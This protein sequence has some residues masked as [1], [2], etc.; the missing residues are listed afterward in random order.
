[1]HLSVAYN[2]DPRLIEEVVKNKYP[3]Y[4]FYASAQHTMVG[5]GRPSFIL[6]GPDREAIQAQIKLMHENKIEFTYVL[7]APCMA[8]QEF[9]RETHEKLI[10]ELQWIQ[11]IGCDGVVLTIPYLMEI[12]KEQFPKLKIRVSTIAKVNTV[13][14]AKYFE[15]LGAS[16]ITPDVMINRNFKVLEKMVKATKCE[17]NLLLTDGCLYECP[18]RQYHYTLCGHASQTFS[19]KAY[20]DYPVVACSISKLSDPAEIIRCRW[21]RPEDIPHYQAIGI[22][23]FKIGGR[24][25]T[26]NRLLVSIKAYSEKKYDGNL[27]DILEGF[28]FIADGIMEE[29]P[30]ADSLKPH[31]RIDN[32]KL[33]GFIDFFKKQDCDANC[34]ECKYCEQWAKKAITMNKMGAEMQL[35]SLGAM[36]KN[37]SNSRFFGLDQDSRRRSKK[38]FLGR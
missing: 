5:G 17:I 8:G 31:L 36:R 27:A 21:V 7:N 37:L 20:Q 10:N 1:M 18:Y 28:A 23:S 19:N 11:D 24:R 25:L 14:K 6:P 13:N 30:S 4:D 2:W 12:V 32:T 9:V 15:S 16:A 3:V 26:T 35:F 34:G 33:D 29:K 38:K 22:N